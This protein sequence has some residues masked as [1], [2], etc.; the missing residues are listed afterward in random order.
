[1]SGT[2]W[3]TLLA[4]C[5]ADINRTGLAIVTAFDVELRSLYSYTVGLSAHEHPELVVVGLRRSIAEPALQAAADGAGVLDRGLRHGDQVHGILAGVALR[6][7]S[8]LDTRRLLPAANELYARPGLPVD[9]LQ[10][11]YP[12][13]TGRMPWQTRADQSVPLLGFGVLAQ[14]V[15]IDHLPGTW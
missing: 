4:R 11:V 6:A 5:R 2:S 10:L 15:S 1:M 8:V 3:Q 9:A 14:D 13:R 7:V 12:D